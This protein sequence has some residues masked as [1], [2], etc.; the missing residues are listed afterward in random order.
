M[1]N[2]STKLRIFIGLLLTAA[3]LILISAYSI[4]LFWQ[5]SIGSDDNKVEVTIV[6]G[7]TPHSIADSLL[8][9][10]II[11]SKTQFLLATKWMGVARELQAGTYRFSG[12]LSYYSILRKLKDGHTIQEK[13]TFPEGMRI[14][15]M[16]QLLE[17]KF[18]IDA[19][20]FIELTRD[21]GYCTRLGEGILSLEGYL[22]PETY[23][24][25]SDVRP[26]EVIE[27]LLSRSLSIL[28]QQLAGQDE[29]IRLSRH[30]IV[31]LASLIE[32][33]ALLDEE[34]PIISAVYH[35]RLERG[36]LLQADP[37]L[38]YLL[39]GKPRRLLDKDLEIESPYNTY[40]HAGLPPGPVNNPGL[41]SIR[42]ALNPAEVNYLYLVA[43][44]DGSHVFSKTNT[45]HIRAKQRF[46]EIRRRVRR[47]TM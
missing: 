41:A 26:E 30:E 28:E 12:R 19:E 46:N 9:L 38:Q 14:R 31:T 32:G 3:L 43:K 33:E 39:P 7:M 15:E 20:Q 23:F 35:N 34:R 10:K 37:T 36:M 29:T 8:Q 16:A 25:R 2:L 47:Q 17:N 21:P 24:F 40:L 13:I 5:W 27:T 45:E 1:I 11:P 42:A 6:R 4:L 22:F 44:G 18:G